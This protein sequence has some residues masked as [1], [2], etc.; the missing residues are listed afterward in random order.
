MDEVV[1]DYKIWLH[2]I[3]TKASRK[4][5]SGYVQ[6]HHYFVFLKDYLCPLIK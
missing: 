1:F 5:C 3:K 2:G 6:V 4:V